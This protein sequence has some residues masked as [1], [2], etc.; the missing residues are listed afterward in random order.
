MSD[1][2]IDRVDELIRKNNIKYKGTSLN[3]YR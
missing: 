2:V 1:E 3:S